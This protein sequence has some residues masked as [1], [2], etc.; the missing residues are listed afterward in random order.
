MAV[1]VMLLVFACMM[2]VPP[3][4]ITPLVGATD[5]PVGAFGTLPAVII[6]SVA[7]LAS[8]DEAVV[9]EAF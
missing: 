9:V 5:T 7:G 6:E 1:G 4:A 2:T 3:P 8:A